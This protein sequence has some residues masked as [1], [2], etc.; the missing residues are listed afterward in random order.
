LIFQN[1][2]WGAPKA[3]KQNQVTFFLRVCRKTLISEVEESD[4]SR[5][6]Q[7]GGP[8]VALDS[9]GPFCRF[10][11]QARRYGASGGGRPIRSSFFC[12]DRE[13]LLFQSPLSRPTAV[14]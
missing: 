8:A 5:S 4:L 11:A 12:S 7:V 10:S 2:I 14:V 13:R 9:I 3:K 1:D 6:S